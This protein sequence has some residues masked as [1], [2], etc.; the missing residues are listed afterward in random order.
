VVAAD[1]RMPG[2]EQIARTQMQTEQYQLHE[3]IEQRHWWF[4]GRRA[5][6]LSLVQDLV[7]ANGH[8]PTVLEIGCGTGGNLEALTGLYQVRGT[9]LS[10]QAIQAARARAPQA[11][12]R[13][14]DNPAK[15]PGWIST[16]SVILLLD[17]LEHIEEDRAFFESV[18]E[19]M[20]PGSYLIVT[21]PAHMG[22]WTKHDE[23]FGHYRRYEESEFTA[24]WDGLPVRTRLFSHYNSRLY[25]IVRLVRALTGLTGTTVGR[26]GTDFS[27][28]PEPIN[29][30]LESAFAGESSRL[31]GSMHG[32][33]LGYR[34]G[35]SLIAVFER[36]EQ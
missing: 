32:S 1:G 30:A 19:R 7:P 20:S 24:L 4:R 18:V 34:Y 22:L 26:A 17:V 11:D 16:A 27:M 13:V 6:L 36:G 33:R 3:D 21:V 28:Y 9:D 25:P 2:P 14:A 35:L 23:S 8:T 31:I 10:P 12:L 15:F 5:I 29:A